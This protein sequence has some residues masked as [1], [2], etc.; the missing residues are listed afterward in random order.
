VRHDTSCFCFNWPSLA[1]LPG[2]EHD[3][4]VE[5]WQF[6]VKVSN[7]VT[8]LIQDYPVIE[9]QRE[10]LLKTAFS[11]CDE[12]GSGS[13][14]SSELSLIFEK[15]GRKPVESEIKLIMKALDQDGNGTIEWNEFRT[16]FLDSGAQTDDKLKLFFNFG[17]LENLNVSGILWKVGGDNAKWTNLFSKHWQKRFA[18]LDTRFKTLSYYS[19]EHAG[20]SNSKPNGVIQLS[21]FSEVKEVAQRKGGFDFEIIPKDQKRVFVFSCDT[22]AERSRFPPFFQVILT[23]QH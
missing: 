20:K 23:R 2:F 13:I 17:M 1:A 14:S 10:N 6:C 15:L 12:D 9:R 22:V 16:Y 21:H 3:F 11:A 19:T 5:A 4:P 8:A 7:Q 18:I